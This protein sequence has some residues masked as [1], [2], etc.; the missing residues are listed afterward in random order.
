MSK[1]P[2]DRAACFC[3]LKPLTSTTVGADGF[4]KEHYIPQWLYSRHGLRQQTL[5]LPSKSEIAYGHLWV[6]CCGGCNSRLNEEVEKRARELIT[7]VPPPW[8]EEDR[9]IIKRWLAKAYLGVRVRATTLPLDRTDPASPTIADQ[10]EIDQAVLLRMIVNGQVKVPHSSLFVYECDPHTGGGFDFWSS[11]VAHTIW[12]AQNQS[13][14]PASSSTD[15]RS[16]PGC[17]PRTRSS[18]RQHLARSTLPPSGWSAL[19]HWPRQQRLT[20]ATTLCT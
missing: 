7:N 15:R 20:S 19:M 5:D 16:R 11:D 8:A 4:T 17:C 1:K 2:I 13:G 6:P 10:K 12:C 9:D 14:W 18:A 3:C